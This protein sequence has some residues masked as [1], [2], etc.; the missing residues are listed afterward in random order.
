MKRLEVKEIVNMYEE[1]QGLWLQKEY[2]AALLRLAN[3]N[4]CLSLLSKQERNKWIGNISISTM[5]VPVIKEVEDRVKKETDKILRIL[6][7]GYDFSFEE[8]TLVLSIRN[9][10]DSLINYLR[11]RCDIE[12]CSTLHNVDEEL[13]EFMSY[14]NNKLLVTDVIKQINSNRFTP[15]S[16]PQ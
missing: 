2:Y 16:S 7:V 14:K 3:I 9:D 4:E 1:F 6:S 5:V 10:I 12:I 11:D 8:I 15:I 13:M